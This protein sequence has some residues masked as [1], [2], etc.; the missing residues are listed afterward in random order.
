[1]QPA[2]PLIVDIMQK[3]NPTSVLDLGCGECKFSKKFIDKGIVVFGIDKDPTAIS[4]ENFTFV[5][6]IY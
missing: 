4:H 2:K 5:Q 6:K 1:M 3:L